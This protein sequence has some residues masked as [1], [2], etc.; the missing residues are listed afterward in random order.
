[1]LRIGFQALLIGLAAGLA[2]CSGVQDGSGPSS[3]IA[4]PSAKP[5]PIATGQ[6]RVI[7]GHPQLSGAYCNSATI[8]RLGPAAATERR[9]LDIS[10]GLMFAATKVAEIDVPAGRY[11]VVETRCQAGNQTTIVRASVSGQALAVFE[12]QT[13]ETVD[14]GRLEMYSLQSADINLG[15][16][17]LVVHQ[18]SIETVAG[19]AGHVPLSAAGAVKR[20][21][22]P[23]V[24]VPPAIDVKACHLE[25]ERQAR[26]L[27]L[28]PSEPYPC[29]LAKRKGLIV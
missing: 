5:R 3:A 23:A 8:E 12:V 17:M 27:V 25:R 28:I 10:F 29:I 18:A 1:M 11:A 19:G 22:Q 15:K 9:R 13:A 16:P 26:G 6:G 20:P 21:M 2:G 4:S 7:I 14:V 24:N